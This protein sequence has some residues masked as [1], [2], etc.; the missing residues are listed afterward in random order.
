MGSP[1]RSGRVLESRLE[2]LTRGQATHRNILSPVVRFKASFGRR[3]TVGLLY[4]ARVVYHG[5]REIV[6]SCVSYNSFYIY[7]DRQLL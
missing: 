7:L 6:D 4:G 1:M 3:V 2:F 5:I